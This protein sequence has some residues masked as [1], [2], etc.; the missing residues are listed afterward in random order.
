ME[1]HDGWAMIPCPMI[2]S[3]EK[4]E[5]EQHPF[6]LEAVFRH[7]PQRV[8]EH[9]DSTNSDVAFKWPGLSRTS[10]LDLS[11]GNPRESTF[12][13][14][15][16][17]LQSIF[18][19]T[20]RNTAHR[21]TNIYQVF[22]WSSLAI[23]SPVWYFFKGVEIYGVSTKVEIQFVQFMT[24]EKFTSGEALRNFLRRKS[25]TWKGGFSRRN[26]IENFCFWS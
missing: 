16:L 20:L 11:C 7:Q 19:E 5:N 8:T 10:W 17:P 26:E 21:F 24:I 12:G 15:S 14:H 18:N 9:R 13:R 3:K 23:M 22:K 4:A 25:F 6:P 1:A 2:F